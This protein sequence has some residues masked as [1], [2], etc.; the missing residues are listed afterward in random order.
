MARIRSIKPEFWTDGTNKRLTDACALFFIGI[1]NFCDDEGKHRMD[2]D[3]LCAELGGRWRKDKVSLF[4]LCLAKSGQIRVSLGSEWFQ[5]TGWSHQKIDKPRQPDVKAADIQ[6]LSQE[7]SAKALE[8][9]RPIDA[10]IGSDRIDRIGEDQARKRKASRTP[11]IAVAPIGR[12]LVAAYFDAYRNRY[13]SDPVLKA[14]DGKALKNFGER[15]G[16]A[17]AKEM[18]EAYLRM[19]H[20]WFITKAHDLTTFLQNLNQV[21]N[22]IS[23]GSVVTAADARNA[24]NADALTNQIKRLGGGL[25]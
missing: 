12:N 24:E 5:T 23:T 19:N 15:V 18:L 11:A 16:E 1:W 21:S 25:G 3:Q 4:L 9:S 17:K 10:R 6:W 22:F 2:L 13:G 20:A 14:Q 7:D 8:R